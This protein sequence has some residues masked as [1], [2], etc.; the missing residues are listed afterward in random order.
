M[1]H[2]DERSYETDQQVLRQI[3]AAHPKTLYQVS[4]EGVIERDSEVQAQAVYTYIERI[5]REFPEVTLK[6]ET[7]EMTT[8]E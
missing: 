3:M 2:G 5:A 1:F 8:A 6:I 7:V 4:V